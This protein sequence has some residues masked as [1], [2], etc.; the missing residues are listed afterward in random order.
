[1][2]CMKFSIHIKTFTMKKCYQW[3]RLSLNLK[4]TWKFQEQMW[5]HLLTFFEFSIFSFRKFKYN[6]FE[7]HFAY[8]KTNILTSASKHLYANSCWH[9]SCIFL[10][11]FCLQTTQNDRRKS[12]SCFV[13]LSVS[14]FTIYSFFRTRL[15]KMTKSIGMYRHVKN[16]KFY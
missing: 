12:A 15:L 2:I 4:H 8:S 14:Q 7:S 1:M 6:E 11:F 10:L 3:C 13:S 9:I 16:N 5:R